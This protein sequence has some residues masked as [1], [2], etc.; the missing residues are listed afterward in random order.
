[1]RKRI[2]AVS[3]FLITT[4]ACA[5]KS[6]DDSRVMGLMWQ[7]WSRGNNGIDAWPAT[8]SEN[9]YDI[10]PILI[11]DGEIILRNVDNYGKAT[12]YAAAWEYYYE[13]IDGEDWA[14]HRKLYKGD[15]V[16]FDMATRCINKDGYVCYSNKKFTLV[17][18]PGKDVYAFR[19]T[20]T[21]KD[22][23]SNEI[24]MSNILWTDQ[25]LDKWT[26]RAKQMR[27]LFSTADSVDINASLYN[28]VKFIKADSELTEYINGEKVVYAAKNTTKTFFSEEL[29]TE[30]FVQLPP[31]VEGVTG[32]GTGQTLHAEFW[33]PYGNV[34]IL[35]GYVDLLNTQLYKEN[36]RVKNMTIKGFDDSRKQVF[37]LSV[38]LNDIPSFQKILFPMK[39]R[40]IDLTIDSVYQG[41]KYND[42]CIRS[43]FAWPYE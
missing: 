13:I 30:L 2:I 35:N 12:G 33:E 22:I 1:M 26:S 36:N 8:P 41:S 34:I 31:W 16:I 6:T 37:S 7:L 18:V 5:Q 19:A 39:V 42:T 27:V 11:T 28:T 9:E 38:I 3:L 21:N 43:V 32:S 17:T 40:F 14:E 25:R 23:G 10:S 24:G 15:D 4:F 20:E 29:T